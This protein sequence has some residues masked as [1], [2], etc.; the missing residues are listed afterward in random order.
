MK[1]L[2]AEVAESFNTIVSRDIFCE[3]FEKF[4]KESVEKYLEESLKHSE[5]ISSWIVLEIFEDILGRIPAE[6]KW[7]ISGKIPDNTP[8]ESHGEMH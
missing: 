5:Q 4:Q 6:I 2:L 7:E 8:K 3:T 1:E